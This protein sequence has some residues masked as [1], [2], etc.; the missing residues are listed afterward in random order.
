MTVTANEVQYAIKITDE[1]INDFH[2]KPQE[3]IPILMKLNLELGFLSPEVLERIS[4]RLHI[5][6]SRVYSIASFY[7]MIYTKP[8]GRHVVKFCES[9]PCH[10]AG[11]REVWKALQKEMGIKPGETSKD[12]RW[13]LFNTSCLGVCAVGPV[14][15]VDEDIYGNLSPDQLPNILAKYP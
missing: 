3:L 1:V 7:H 11:G 15:M 12:G 14:M 8:T 9:A 2:A 10:V 13:T 6:S 4:A 5:P